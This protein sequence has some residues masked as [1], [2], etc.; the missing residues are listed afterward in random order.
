[1]FQVTVWAQL[2]RMCER[3]LQ[4]NSL[5]EAQPKIAYSVIGGHHIGHDLATI[6]RERRR[7]MVVIQQMRSVI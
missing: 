2:D 1:M 5:V 6:C 3:R 7:A 4:G